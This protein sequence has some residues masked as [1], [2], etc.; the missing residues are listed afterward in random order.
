MKYVIWEF[1]M[2]NICWV[3]VCQNNFLELFYMIYHLSCN[4]V[5]TWTFTEF[6]KIAVMFRVARLTALTVCHFCSMLISIIF[7]F[8]LWTPMIFNNINLE[9]WKIISTNTIIIVSFQKKL[10]DVKF[11]YEAIV[12]YD[13]LFY[14]F[15]DYFTLW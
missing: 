7:S 8:S 15:W 6:V 3:D 5:M 13:L 10:V 4:S 1:N 2:E 12:R 9:S 14:C 11:S